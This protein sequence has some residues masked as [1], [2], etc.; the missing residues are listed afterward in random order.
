MVQWIKTDRRTSRVHRVAGVMQPRTGEGEM[1]ASVAFIRETLMVWLSRDNRT[2]GRLV[3]LILVDPPFQATG[4]QFTAPHAPI[5]QADGALSTEIKRWLGSDKR[6]RHRLYWSAETLPPPISIRAP[7]VSILARELSASVERRA[8]VLHSPFT[9][10]QGLYQA[11]A[12]EWLLVDEY[13][14]RELETIAFMLEHGEQ[15]LHTLQA[16]LKDLFAMK[17]RWTRYM[18]LVQD[19]LRQCKNRAGPC[20]DLQPRVPPLPPTTQPLHPRW[21]SKTSSTSCPVSIVHVRASKATS[22]YYLR[23]YPS[24]RLS[25]R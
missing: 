4:V 24:A 11:V 23:L 6:W 22:L 14:G 2:A 8:Q 20:G 10:L 7:L 25:K 1:M 13:V 21:W 12:S 3:G 18:E 17:R 5:T 19:T 9:A 15:K 16:F